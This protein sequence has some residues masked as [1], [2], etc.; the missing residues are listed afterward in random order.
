MVRLVYG[1]STFRILLFMGKLNDFNLQ[2]F[3]DTYKTERLIETGTGVGNSLLHALTFP[4]LRIDSCEI[5]TEQALRLKEKFANEPRVHIAAQ[6]SAEFLCT[7]LR[8][9]MAAPDPILFYLDAHYPGSDLGLRPYDAEE[10]AVLRLP[11]ESE[12]RMIKEYRPYAKD[13][14][15][16][17]D[18]RIYKRG[19]FESKN[20]DEIGLAH[21][22][23]Y[24]NA[25][26][27]YDLFGGTHEIEEFAHDT[28]YLLLVPR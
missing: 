21:I 8:D 2:Y 27:A 1:G 22:G 13:V 4:F 28:G 10:S 7:L 19:A 25:Q 15:I 18:L 17:D 26:F 20:L 6:E 9:E 16:A 23:Q 24:N 3:I 12:L 5:V 14:I 11:L